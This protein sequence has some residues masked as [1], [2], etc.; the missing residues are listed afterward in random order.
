[1]G[2][3]TDSAD[4]RPPLA[5]HG[6]RLS[7]IKNLFCLKTQIDLAIKWCVNEFRAYGYK[8]KN[9]KKLLRTYW[10]ES[11]FAP[12][13]SIM[14]HKVSSCEELQLLCGKY[15]SAGRRLLIIMIWAA[16]QFPPISVL[17]LAMH[18]VRLTPI[19]TRYC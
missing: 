19:K 7:P 11:E 4:Q 3:V 13:A 8:Y 12:R 5:M 10:C 14:V 9:S 1:M 16:L 6:V 17:L 18:G 15:R 2:R